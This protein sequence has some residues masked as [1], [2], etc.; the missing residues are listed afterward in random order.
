[1]VVS[2]M[3]YDDYAFFLTKNLL[4]IW[5]ES[6]KLKIKNL[7]EHNTIKQLN[8]LLREQEEVDKMIIHLYL[9]RIKRKGV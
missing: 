4:N 3:D 6:V 1:M 9:Q 7:Q 8:D 5:S 2:R